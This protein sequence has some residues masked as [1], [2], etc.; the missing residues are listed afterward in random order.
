MGIKP[1]PEKGNNS[2]YGGVGKT[3]NDVHIKSD[4]HN[5]NLNGT[6]NLRGENGQSV[7]II[8]DLRKNP[9]MMRNLAGMISNEMSVIQKGANVIQ[10]A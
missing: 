6:L 5:I 9:D 7:D 1:I 10:R 3:N 2:T 8:S 4:P